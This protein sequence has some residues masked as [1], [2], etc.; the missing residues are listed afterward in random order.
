MHVADPGFKIYRQV[1]SFPYQG[2]FVPGNSDG[3]IFDHSVWVACG[4]RGQMDVQPEGVDLF[5]DYV[6]GGIHFALLSLIRASVA[7][8][9]YS[10]PVSR[11]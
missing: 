1:G 7:V 8:M 10:G 11:G 6:F 3:T 4:H 9:K 2:N 5:G